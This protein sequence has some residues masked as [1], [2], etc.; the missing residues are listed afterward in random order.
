M[1][2]LFKIYLIAFLSVFPVLGYG[3]DLQKL[4]DQEHL[5]RIYDERMK[6]ERDSLRQLGD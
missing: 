5:Q 6:R 3:Q 4:T 2:E 1:K